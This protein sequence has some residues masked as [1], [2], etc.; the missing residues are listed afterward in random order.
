M[1]SPRGTLEQW[2]ALQAVVEHG[3]YVQAAE[4][5]FRSQST[6]SYAVTKLQA[7]LGI[8]LL[9]VHGRKATLTDAGAVLLRRSRQLLND[10]AEIEQLAMQLS[11]GREAE[12]HFVVDAA[13][14][15]AMLMRVLKRFSHVCEGTRVQLKEAVLSGGGEALDAGNADLVICG[16]APPQFL[17]NALLDVEFVAVAH[18]DHALHRLN[19]V[20]SVSDLSRELQVV[21]RDSG[22]K[23]NVD[24][25]W[26]GAEHR[27]TVTSIQSAAAAIN[28]GLGFA[29]LPRHEV[30][31]KLDAGNLKVLPLREGQTYCVNLKLIFGKPGSTGPATQ[32]LADLLFDTA[33]H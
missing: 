30:Q 16:R 14:P 4:Q 1:N 9:E 21:I 28:A 31:D 26:L 18:P 20:L 24:S 8:K 17:G 7:L 19:R 6:I 15:T 22:V 2:R 13:F 33:R 5:L 10:A 29:W 11:Q 25:G 32:Q 27:W 3:G 12:I 23:H